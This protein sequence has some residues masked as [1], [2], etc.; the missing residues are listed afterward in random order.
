MS[1]ITIYLQFYTLSPI[2]PVIE[3]GDII[4]N[5]ILRII[6]KYLITLE[7][8]LDNKMHSHLLSTIDD[9]ATISWDCQNA[10]P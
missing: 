5:K 9:H 8:A 10:I 2:C 3:T 1:V 7:H 4:N 6:A